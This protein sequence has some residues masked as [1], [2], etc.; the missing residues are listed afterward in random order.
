MVLRTC[1]FHVF[2]SLVLVVA[3]AGSARGGIIDNPGFED[4]VDFA[5][6]SAQPGCVIIDPVGASPEGVRYAY[7]GATNVTVALSQRFIVPNTTTDLSV[8]LAW[9]GVGAVSSS[10]TIA[11][12]SGASIVVD[13]QAAPSTSL[14]GTFRTYVADI[15]ALQGREVELLF[16]ATSASSGD[17]MHQWIDDVRL[18]PEPSVL[19]V[20]LTG[21]GALAIRRSRR[22][23]RV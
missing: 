6:W 9:N 16:T 10:A 15:T 7:Q 17:T 23:L 21:A 1:S 20:V 3:V 13:I 12:V 22:H 11:T 19:M 14:F 8:V 2:T 5:G 18:I 4:L